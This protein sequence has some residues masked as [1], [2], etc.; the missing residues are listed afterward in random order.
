MKCKKIFLLV[1]SDIHAKAT[2]SVL[3]FFKLS[4]ILMKTTLDF[5]TIVGGIACSLL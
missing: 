3:K 4:L 2:K 1:T 5:S